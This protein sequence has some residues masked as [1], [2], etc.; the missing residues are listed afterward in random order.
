MW[1]LWLLGLRAIWVQSLFQAWCD[2]L[3]VKTDAGTLFSVFSKDRKLGLGPSGRAQEC[4]IAGL[5]S[6]D[7]DSKAPRGCGRRT[8]AC[9][10]IYYWDHRWPSC[11]LNLVELFGFTFTWPSILFSSIDHFLVFSSFKWFDHWPS[12]SYWKSVVIPWLH[13]SV[14][15]TCWFTSSCD[16]ESIHFSTTSVPPWFK[17]LLPQSSAVVPLWVFPWDLKSTNSQLEA[18]RTWSWPLYSLLLRSQTALRTKEED[19]GRPGCHPASQPVCALRSRHPDFLSDPPLACSRY[20]PALSP[21]HRNGL[22]SLVT[23]YSHPSYFITVSL[24]QEVS[25]SPCQ[26]LHCSCVCFIALPIHMNK[27]SVVT[28]PISN[29]SG[30][31][32]FKYLSNCIVVACLFL[33]S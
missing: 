13:G 26:Q 4:W 20:L 27:S 32:S 31:D 15:E 33:C 29:R 12:C 30:K 17:P 25:Q 14:S 1:T 7:A 22:P 21:L 18:W 24:L 8:E 3:P 10:R 19:R 23:S 16:S 2:W 5:W 6:V 9:C 11:L 28:S